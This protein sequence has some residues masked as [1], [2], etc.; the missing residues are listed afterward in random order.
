MIRAALE[1]DADRLCL[2]YN[3]YIENTTVTF[4]ECV[5]DWRTMAARMLKV[6][7][8]GLPWLVLQHDNDLIGYA[9]AT[10]WRDRSA[11]RF[12][13]EVSVYLNP[14]LRGQGYGTALYAALFDALRLSKRPIHLAIGGITLPN[15]ASAAL[16]EKFGMQQAAHFREVGRK[17]D[18][19]L[20]VGYWQCR[21]D[22]SAATGS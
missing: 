11:Y 19:W 21:L 16:H 3:H 8:E 9:Y 12:S 22:D 4:E 14:Q 7:N 2:I 18:T 15:P 20:D 10:P 6:R 1:S 13:V 5:I 17:F